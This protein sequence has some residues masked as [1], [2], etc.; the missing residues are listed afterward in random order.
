MKELLNEQQQ[1]NILK[2][3]RDTITL[4]VKNGERLQ[5]SST[6]PEL[7][8]KCGAFVTLKIDEDLRGCIGFITSPRP[9]YETI[10][11][12]AIASATEDPRFPPLQ[13]KELDLITIEISVLSPPQKI[14]DIKEIEAGKHGL[15]IS[16][17]FHRG[18]L[19]PQVAT[20]NKWDKITFLR[21]TCSKA[22]LPADAWQE[23]ATIE[24][25][26]AQVFGE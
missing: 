9:L 19:L 10:I 11:D 4:Y 18:L 21:H 15:I 26:S 14:E 3:A 24:I 6:E 13:K 8:S 12:A 5:F 17:G 20:E 16:K 1:K 23:G 22:G 7:Q 2:L 25:F